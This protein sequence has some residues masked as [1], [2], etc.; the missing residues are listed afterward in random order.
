VIEDLLAQYTKTGEQLRTH[1]GDTTEFLHQSLT[2]GK[3]LLFEGA[4]GTLLDVDHGTYPFVTS[5]SSSACGLASGS[6][7]PGHRVERYVGVI[8]A[9]TTRVGE[10][11]FPTELRDSVGEHIRAR[12]REYGTVTGRPRRC[13]WFDAVLAR[14]S[15]KICGVHALAV[16]LLDVL[17]ELDELSICV[18]YECRGERRAVPP[19][20]TEQLAECTPVYIKKPGWRRD[21][22]GVRR[23]S[24][25]PAQAR[26]YLDTL[27]ELVGAPVEIVSV[28]PDRDQTI[29]MTS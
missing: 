23:L 9:Y 6:G 3:R 17:S 16:M 27:S 18:A 24:D 11:P 8:K 5:S 15:A 26:D 29:R 7:V 28:G 2:A 13:G 1:I 21:I 4:Q 20:D 12:G 19:S 14:Y 10:G 25:L 22:A